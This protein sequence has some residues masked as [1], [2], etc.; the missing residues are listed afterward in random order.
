[1]GEVASLERNEWM[2]QADLVRSRGKDK[3]ELAVTTMFLSKLWAKTKAGQAK[4]VWPG[5]PWKEDFVQMLD[6]TQQAVETIFIEVYGSF[7]ELGLPMTL[8]HNDFH[9]M[10]ILLK[11]DDP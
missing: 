11:P 4:G 10:N 6:E 1:M 8:T 5:T 7:E 3:S 9:G 2:F